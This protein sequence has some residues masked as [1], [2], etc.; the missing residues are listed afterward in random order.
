MS[1]RQVDRCDARPMLDDAVRRAR[2]EFLEMPGLK[3]TLP[4]AAR[5]W[6]YEARFCRDVLAALVDAQFLVASGD[7]FVRAESRT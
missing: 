3:L 1:E 2:G 7:G 6:A 5:L 4:Q